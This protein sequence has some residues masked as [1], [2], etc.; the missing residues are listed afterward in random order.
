MALNTVSDHM[1][2]FDDS[3]SDVISTLSN[4]DYTFLLDDY[5]LN[6]DTL[7]SNESKEREQSFVNIY[8]K[9]SESVSLRNRRRSCSVQNLG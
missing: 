5:E 2:A 7:S 8:G 9:E 3:A 4:V 6:N 1:N